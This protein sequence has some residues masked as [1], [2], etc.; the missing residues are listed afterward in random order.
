[1]SFWHSRV[2][3]AWAGAVSTPYTGTL[4]VRSRPEAMGPEGCWGD[5]AL[6]PASTASTVTVAISDFI[7]APGG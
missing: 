4:K 1:M 7:G 3:A 5:V 2:A 6:Q